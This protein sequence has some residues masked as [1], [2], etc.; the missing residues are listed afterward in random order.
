MNTPVMTQY[1]RD[2]SL[3]TTVS[4][5]ID[6]TGAGDLSDVGAALVRAMHRRGMSPT[7][8][9][10]QHTTLTTDGT[11]SEIMRQSRAE[12]P[13]LID[14]F[15]TTPARS[16][17][18]CVFAHFV[19]AAADLGVAYSAIA[20]FAYE[21]EIVL[22]GEFHSVFVEQQELHLIVDIFAS[23]ALTRV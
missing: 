1:P 16:L 7:G 12:E 23:T 20:V 3:A 4:T 2:L 10:I 15:T 21:H 19:G 17:S 6:S 9:L 13:I 22:T 8:P 5:L 14:G 18:Q 11:R